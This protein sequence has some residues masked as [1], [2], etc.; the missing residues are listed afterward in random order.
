MNSDQEKRLFEQ[1]GW[2]YDFIG[3][4]WVAPDG[5]R[6]PQN[7]LVRTTA[8]PRGEMALMR[9]IVESGKRTPEVMP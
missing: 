8:Q 3:R 6:L 1:Y 5:T 4:A 2:T 9:L 7:E